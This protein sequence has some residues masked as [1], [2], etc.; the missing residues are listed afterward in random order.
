MQSVRQKIKDA[1]RKQEQQREEEEIRLQEQA[2]LAEYQRESR[3][4]ND[5]F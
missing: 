2:A 3:E 4:M 5:A 1:I